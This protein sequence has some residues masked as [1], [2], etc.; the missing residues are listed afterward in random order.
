MLW[1]IA[2]ALIVIA[3]LNAPLA[4]CALSLAALNGLVA[5]RPEFWWIET[6]WTF[7]LALLLLAVQLLADLYF[8][9]IRVRDRLYL[10]PQR[11]ANNYVHA[12]FQSL[13]RPLAAAVLI[14]ALPLP[15]PD[16]TLAVVGFSLATACYWLSAWVREHVAVA[17]GALVLLALE[18]LKNATLLAAAALLFWLPPLALVLLL[19]SLLPTAAWTLRLQREVIVDVSYGG[20]R[21][22]EDS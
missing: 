17:R 5:L 19:L 13:F 1:L 16:W 4:I 15:A 9:P 21:A 20:R 12:R 11:T 10:N 6:P 7:V 22:G 18:T 8:V 2:L 3:G 14:A